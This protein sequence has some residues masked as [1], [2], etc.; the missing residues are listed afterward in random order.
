MYLKRFTPNLHK[1]AV[2]AL[3][4]AL[5][6]VYY[7]I[8]NV[9]FPNRL[10]LLGHDYSAV[11]TWVLDGYFWLR[12]NPIYEVPWFSPSFCG[13]QPF[14]ANAG[15]FFYSA[16]TLLSIFFDPLESVRI[17]F[18]LFAAIGAWGMHR[19]L[20]D[21]FGASVAAALVGGALFLFNGFYAHRVIV[22]HATYE[23]FM[24]LPWIAWALLFASVPA[25]SRRLRWLEHCQCVALAGLMVSYWVFS[26]F[27][28][29][30]VPAGMAVLAVAAL[31]LAQDGRWRLFLGRSAAGFAVAVALAASALLAG[32]AFM[33]HFPRSD[34]LLPGISSATSAVAILFDALF[35][36]PY[37]IEDI[38]RPV[39]A[40]VQW[41]LSRH[42]WEYGMTVVPLLL[43]VLS[44]ALRAFNWRTA[45]VSVAL[46]ARRLAA[47]VV[48]AVILAIPL[49]VNLYSPGWNA[50]L[51]QLPV[52]KSSSA[53]IR[54]WLIYIPVTIVYA[55]LA[56]DRTGWTD[57]Y[58]SGLALLSIVGII[59]LNA[60][61]D[62]SFYHRQ[63]Y[64][65]S[66]TV[67]SYAATKRGEFTPEIDG[68]AATLNSQGR[69]MAPPERNDV[70][71]NGK[72]QLAC[73]NPS[74][75]Y[76]LE[77]LPLKTLH[78]GSIYEERDGRLN[79][80]NPAC[81][82]F[83]EENHCEPGDHFLTSQLAE[84]QAFAHYKPF[85]FEIS[86]R[87]RVANWV[88]TVAVIVVPCLLLFAAVSLIRE[89]RRGGV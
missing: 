67:N 88:S 59:C 86:T 82:V 74:F 77:H 69:I 79:L 76:R 46:D 71:V 11:M 60:I 29:L 75:G 22:G 55:A 28:S 6:L 73:Y 39:L 44:W 62:R 43:I 33:S 38:V 80:K 14:F 15:G 16:P 17:S 36:S 8:F 18:M 41:G 58:K 66:V 65:P 56:V 19:L 30:V 35:L 72:S 20:R 51:K 52:L 34:Y 23:G 10:G 24:L 27:V 21:V 4:V 25:E 81:Y 50:F 5:L 32:Q 2:V 49:V 87:Q 40:N 7:R 85:P 68:I 83:P 12:N 9:F 42:E 63:T 3:Y 37:D 13:G 47:L 64:D 57:R 89:R 84:A 54:W 61:H 1:W 70:M 53:L 26:G 31:S 45:K 78:P 48:L